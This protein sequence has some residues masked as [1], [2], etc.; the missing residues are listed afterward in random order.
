MLGG[1]LNVKLLIGE[2]LRVLVKLRSVVP[3]DTIVISLTRATWL[4]SGL[5]NTIVFVPRTTK[6]D[7]SKGPRDT[8]LF[9]YG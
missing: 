3:P 9:M 4:L 5:L 2:M 8:H 6:L 1:K 7:M